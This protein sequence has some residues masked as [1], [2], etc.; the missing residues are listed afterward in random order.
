MSIF[1]VVLFAAFPVA[2]VGTLLLIAQY[3][4]ITLTLLITLFS[5][6]TGF[7]MCLRHLRSFAE[8]NEKLEE[9]YLGDVP[10]GIKLVSAHDALMTFIL[11]FL[12]LFPG[13]LSDVVAYFLL[14]PRFK[15]DFFG[16][17]VLSME[18]EAQKQGKSLEEF[19]TPIK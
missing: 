3:I 19:L 10:T 11:M 17:F 16:W 8:R 18:R 12:F 9:K 5:C 14:V 13:L 1:K 15:E 4:G 6:V 7:Y 2:D